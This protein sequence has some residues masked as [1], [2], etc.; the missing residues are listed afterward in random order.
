M[1]RTKKINLIVNNRLRTFY[2]KAYN[3]VDFFYEDSPY[4]KPSFKTKTIKEFLVK[5]GMRPLISEKNAKR[6][7]LSMVRTFWKEVEKDMLDNNITFQFP[8]KFMTMKLGEVEIDRPNSAN[9]YFDKDY[10]ITF[11]QGLNFYIKTKGN[12]YLLMLSKGTLKK[13]NNNLRN[14]RSY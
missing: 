10:Y 6:L 11:E 7:A 4:F 3:L 14:G 2:S 13:F 5:H 9:Y 8:G 12:S 1:A